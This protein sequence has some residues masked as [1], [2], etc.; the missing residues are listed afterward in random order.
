MQGT[1]RQLR[2]RTAVGKRMD[3]KTM[4]PTLLSYSTESLLPA[5]Y[6]DKI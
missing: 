1:V 5:V 6:N 4:P 3:F 2:P